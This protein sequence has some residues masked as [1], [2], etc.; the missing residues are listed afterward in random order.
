MLSTDIIFDNFSY[1]R[2]PVKFQCKKCARNLLIGVG[3]SIFSRE[4]SEQ[5]GILPL[6]KRQFRQTAV[7]F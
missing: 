5:M 2:I 4:D 7:T 6:S 3:H 1:I